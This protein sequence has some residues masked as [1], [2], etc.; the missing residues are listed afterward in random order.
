MIPCLEP[1]LITIAWF[2]WYNIDWKSPSL[3]YSKTVLLQ[4]IPG[5][6]FAAR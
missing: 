5:Q 6:R 3:G 1:V 2:S 4:S